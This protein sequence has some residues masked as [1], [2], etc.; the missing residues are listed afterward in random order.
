M[1]NLKKI[2]N[3]LFKQTTELKSHDVE[4]GTIE[5][6]IKQKQ[7]E[8]EKLSNDFNGYAAN[9]RNVS[10][11]VSRAETIYKEAKKAFEKFKSLEKKVDDEIEFANRNY[12]IMKRG[13]FKTFNDFTDIN[14]ELGQYGARV[15]GFKDNQKDFFDGTRAW[16]SIRGKF[17]KI[18]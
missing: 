11:A 7:K 8:A 16:D 18:K 3:K 15:K 17:K 4:L 14:H 1:S 2:G 9:G 13:G 12:D 5:D 10:S 6:A